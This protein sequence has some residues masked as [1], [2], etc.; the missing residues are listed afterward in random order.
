MKIVE[1]DPNSTEAI[2]L[3]DELSN[4]LEAI[5]LVFRC[6]NVKI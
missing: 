1:R 6:C 4:S 2:L 5:T 3:M